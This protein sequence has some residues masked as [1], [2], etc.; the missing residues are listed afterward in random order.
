MSNTTTLKSEYKDRIDDERN[1][2][3]SKSERDKAMNEL[4]R[5]TEK[6]KLYD[7]SEPQPAPLVRVPKFHNLSRV[8]D[9]IE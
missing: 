6:L 4:I 9:T 1:P 8:Y 7:W 3:V 5:E 2:S